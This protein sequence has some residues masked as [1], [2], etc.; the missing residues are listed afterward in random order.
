[1]TVEDDDDLTGLRR[2]GVAVAAARDAIVAAAEPGVSTME[3]DA[4]GREVLAQHGARSAPQA[5][6]DF[7]G[8]TCL[9]ILPEV[10]HGIP[11]AR[12]L[13]DGDVL[14]IDVSAELDDYW[15]DTG[16]TI[17]IGSAGHPADRLIATTHLAQ[18]DAMRA[19]R[20]GAPLRSI[21]K[22]ARRRAKAAG[23]TTIANL[24]GHGVGRFIHEPPSVSTVAN[25][26]D[27]SPLWEG[28][29][30]AIEPFLSTRAT[31]AHEADDGWTL[32]V[33]DASLVAQVEHT[34]VVT[35]GEPIVLTAS[36][37]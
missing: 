28:L 2:S 26:G 29:V 4:L 15:T 7:P 34:V 3:L 18:A 37:A 32:Y 12:R 13:R 17:T 8:T 6:Y 23:F 30:L 33:R 16:I 1:M 27:G 9:S 24:T 21:G 14:N 5:A 11:S 36:A 22:A 35:G 10:A 20:A 25:A 19:A 31:H